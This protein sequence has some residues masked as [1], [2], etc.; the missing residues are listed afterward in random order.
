M[1]LKGTHKFRVS[2]HQVFNAILNPQILQS[3]IPGCS[4]IE[5][6]DS[7][8]L[9]AH[10]TTKLPGLR[11]PF[12]VVISIAQVQAPNFLVLQVHRKGTGGSVKATSQ[13]NIT[14]EPD[15]ALLSYNANADLDG[16]IKIADNPIGRSVTNN[17][18]NNFFENLEKAL[19]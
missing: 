1:E 7:S 12:G 11:G 5:L 9:K 14:D 4:S 3:C 17:T 16:P 8:R 6:L 19:A 15:G 13:I 10:I 2:S 18:L